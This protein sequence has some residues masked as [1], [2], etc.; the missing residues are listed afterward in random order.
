VNISIL[1]EVGTECMKRRVW[2]SLGI[3]IVALGLWGMLLP[4]GGPRRIDNGSKI[5]CRMH[6]ESIVLAK[7]T[8]AIQNDVARGTRVTVSDLINGKIKYLPSMPMCPRGGTYSVGAIGEAPK[9][10]LEGKGHSLKSEE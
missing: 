9:C 7:K 1:F 6:L 3:G 10:S 8:W 4:I 5:R 2:L